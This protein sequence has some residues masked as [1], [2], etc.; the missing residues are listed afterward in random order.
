MQVLVYKSTLPIPL[1]KFKETT[2]DEFRC[3]RLGEGE[4]RAAMDCSKTLFPASQMSS[5]HGVRRVP[6]MT[7]L[8]S[9]SFNHGQRK[10]PLTLEVYALLDSVTDGDGI[11]GVYGLSVCHAGAISHRDQIRASSNC[12]TQSV[13]PSCACCSLLL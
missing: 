3:E 2:G 12:G 4:K 5:D 10:S 6:R 9:L 11:M 8:F 1:K 13:N 7:A